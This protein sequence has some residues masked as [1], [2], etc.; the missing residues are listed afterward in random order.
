MGTLRR[1]PR[2]AS[3]RWR[4]TTGKAR[5][6]SGSSG[7]CRTRRAAPPTNA[8]GTAARTSACVASTPRRSSWTR[9]AGSSTDRPA[10]RR[11]RRPRRF[12]GVSADWPRRPTR[13]RRTPCLKCCTEGARATSL[14]TARPPREDGGR[15]GVRIRRGMA[16]DPLAFMSGGGEAGEAGPLPRLG[17][18][19]ARPR[20]ELAG[21]IKDH[22]R[23]PAA[24]SP[25]RCSSGGGETSLQIYN[26]AYLPSFGTGKHPKAMG[27]RGSD[28]WQE[29]WPIIKPQI[30]DVM[31]ARQ[32]ELERRPPRAHL[33]QRPHRRG[34][35]DVRLLPRPCRRWPIGGTLVVCMETAESVIAQRQTGCF[36]GARAGLARGQQLERHPR[37]HHRGAGHARPRD[38]PFAAIAH[39]EPRSRHVGLDDASNGHA[40]ATGCSQHDPSTSTSAPRCGRWTRRWLPAPGRSR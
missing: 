20:G 38:V 14:W 8:A 18:D 7:P 25:A 19:A 37:R 13:R 27:Q 28:C 24:F 26:D 6:R 10:N 39:P 34:L 29:I 21:C 9:A 30:D 33:P 1:Q 40:R 17:A 32:A 36:A 35:L 12:P 15:R 11:T 2:R 16:R 4:S 5:R 3:R 22:G 31:R 23:H